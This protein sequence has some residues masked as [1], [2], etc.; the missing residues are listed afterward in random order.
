MLRPAD[1]SV[2]WIDLAKSGPSGRY[3][4]RMA[5]QVDL[6]MGDKL[7]SPFYI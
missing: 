7:G 5:T 2:R 1:E 4:R 3:N 6:P